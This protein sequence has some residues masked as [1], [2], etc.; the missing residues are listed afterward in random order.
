MENNIKIS[1]IVPVYNVEPYVERCLRSVLDQT[2][3]HIEIIVVDDCGTDNSMQV[4]EKVI[5]EHANG[6]KVKVLVQ[7]ENK[8]LSAARN[9]GI[10]E[11]TGEYLYF[12]DSD[13]EIKPDCLEKIVEPVQKHG[14]FDLVVG[15]YC[16]V[17]EATNPIQKLGLLIDSGAIEGRESIARTYCE[18]GWLCVVWNRLIRKEFLINHQLY[19]YKGIIYEDFLWTWQTLNWLNK[20]YVTA[21]AVYYYR[22]RESSL[23]RSSMKRKIKSWSVI[24]KTI[25]DYGRKNGILDFP[26]CVQSIEYRKTLHLME[27][28]NSHLT[29]EEKKEGYMRIRRDIYPKRMDYTYVFTYNKR[30]MLDNMHYLFPKQI[31]FYYLLSFLYIVSKVNKIRY[32]GRA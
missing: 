17:D 9:R 23:F 29:V 16:K 5:A 8:G 27:L 11:A 2:Y 7:E 30:D 19:F 6:W 24:Y 26:F 14:D 31:G 12:I 3:Q 22:Q 10:D 15:N 28:L 21:E 4:V 20:I 1:V 32:R 13:D 18:V 25:K